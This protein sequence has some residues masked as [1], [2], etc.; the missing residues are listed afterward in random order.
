M[1]TQNKK[2]L[3]AQAIKSLQT[4]LTLHESGYKLFAVTP[5]GKSP[6]R[7]G[8]QET[9]EKSTKEYIESEFEYTQNMGVKC[10][11]GLIVI[12]LDTKNDGINNFKKFTQSIGVDFD[13]LVTSTMTV[14]TPSLGIH[15]YLQYSGKLPP[16][17]S[18]ICTGVD[19]RADGSLVVAPGSNINGR[20]YFTKNIWPIDTLAELPPALA[21]S[22]LNAK[23]EKVEVNLEKGVL[24]V[25]GQRNQVITSELGKLRQ[26]LG[27]GYDGLLEHARLLN[28]QIL[29][30][31]LSDEELQTISKSI[32]GYPVETARI[33]AEFETHTPKTLPIA[34]IAD[35]DHHDFPKRN[36]VMSERYCQSYVSSLVASGGTGKTR[37]MMLDAYSVATGRP[38]SGFEV[39]RKGKVLVYN[40]ED[41]ADDFRLRAAAIELNYAIDPQDRKNILFLTKG[42]LGADNNLVV[43]KGLG[44]NEAQ[45]NHVAIS[46]I[47]Q[48]IR[49]NDIKLFMVDP[50][51]NI[52]EGLEENSNPHMNTV[53]R[54][55]NIIAKEA[56][57]A[58]GIA[59]HMRKG[60]NDRNSDDAGASRGA[61]AVVDGCRIVYNLSGMTESESEKILGAK[62]HPEARKYVKLVP[63]KANLFMPKEASNWFRTHS[64]TL[65]NDQMDATLV[66]DAEANQRARA[67]QVDTKNSEIGA[68]AEVLSTYMQVGDVL[69]VNG[70]KKLIDADK[71][72]FDHLFKWAGSTWS[73]KIQK[74]FVEPVEYHDKV[75]VIK[76]AKL[77]GTDEGIYC[78]AKSDLVNQNFIDQRAKSLT[79]IEDI[80]A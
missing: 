13:S 67:I 70:V 11:N 33:A 54:A 34:C 80:F 31:P 77:K 52:Y 57:C 51:V 18:K 39:K 9:A 72:A 49:E 8:W 74:Y 46:T 61:S 59:H 5:N 76:K 45:I 71:G 19:I 48:A 40:T 69:S 35:Y 44:K 32:A 14:T 78:L 4:F 22:I 62:N 2:G 55:L 42:M 28:T 63:T 10:G 21:Y 30:V 23:K 79:Q 37:L 68:C 3:E 7:K 26:A 17:V 25:E 6:F 16:S 38:L 53:I 15:I 36:W 29:G 75:F 24:A 1:D 12:D 64:L 47:V 50:F 20:Y 58:V 66:W 43:A 73:N 27:L 65:P 60:S 56:N 41:D